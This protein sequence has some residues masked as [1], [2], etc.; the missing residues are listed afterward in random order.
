MGQICAE[1]SSIVSR[2]GRRNGGVFRLP[3]GKPLEL[4][5]HLLASGQRNVE[6]EI[7]KLKTWMT[8]IGKGGIW[9]NEGILQD[10]EK[11]RMKRVQEIGSKWFLV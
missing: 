5:L 8:V 11:W 10:L 4:E 6:P 7:E 2:E 9:R 3:T 1:D